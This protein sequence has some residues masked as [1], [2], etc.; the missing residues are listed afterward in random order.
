[1]VLA[2]SFHVFFRNI[3][4]NFPDLIL[5][6]NLWQREA[7]EYLLTWLWSSR[8]YRIFI[9]LAVF[10]LTLLLPRMTLVAGN[11][12]DWGQLALSRPASS[13]P[14]CLPLPPAGHMS[15]Q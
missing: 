14:S 3:P 6:S 5:T 8:P 2:R 7:L 13:L 1:M 11:V 9:C 15:A 12:F 4:C 10:A